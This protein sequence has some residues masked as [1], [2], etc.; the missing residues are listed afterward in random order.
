M[1]SVP[2]E[3]NPDSSGSGGLHLPDLDPRPST[4]AALRRFSDL[5]RTEIDFVWRLLRRIGLSRP[6]A[7]D[8]AQQV[9]IVASSKLAQVPVGKERNFLYGTALRVAANIRRGLRRR[10]LSPVEPPLDTAQEEDLP[11]EILERRRARALLDELLAELPDELARVLVLAEIEQLTLAAIAELEGIP[12]GTAASR[13][14]RARA[15][16]RELLEANQHRNPFE[17]RS[18]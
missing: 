16:F 14:R 2:G 5:V 9:F 18:P 11:D 1:R 4:H 12:P 10:R 8:A 3:P 17:R 6:D 7:D 13:L 15:T